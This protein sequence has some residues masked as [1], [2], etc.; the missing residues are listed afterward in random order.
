MNFKKAQINVL[1]LSL[2]SGY[3]IHFIQN[4]GLIDFAT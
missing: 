2:V 1:F 3:D 4:R